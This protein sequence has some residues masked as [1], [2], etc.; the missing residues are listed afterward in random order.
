MKSLKSLGLMLLGF[1]MS[2]NAMAQTELAN[3]TFETG[4]DVAD[5]VYTPNES[6]WT[7][8]GAQWFNAGAPSFLPNSAAGNAAD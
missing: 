1:G 7:A 8:V 4:Y 5:G 2:V 3:W 6:E